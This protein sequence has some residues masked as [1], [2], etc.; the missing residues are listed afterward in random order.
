MPTSWF[1]FPEQYSEQLHFMRPAQTADKNKYDS[2]FFGWNLN[3]I[4]RVH[5]PAHCN[6]RLTHALIDETRE[7]EWI[8]LI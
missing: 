8:E 5:A 4:S 2:H 1:T 6:T 7:Y 3:L